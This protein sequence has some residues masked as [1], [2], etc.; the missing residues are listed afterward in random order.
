MNDENPYLEKTFTVTSKQYNPNYGDDR[1]C[2][3]DH[4]YIKH[5]E[6]L[7]I[8]IPS[9][10]KLCGCESFNEKKEAE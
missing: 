6:L 1:I 5:F 3:C 7:D 10:C 2:E 9:P 4:R 8:P